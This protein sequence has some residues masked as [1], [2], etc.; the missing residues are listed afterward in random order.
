MAAAEACSTVPPDRVYFIDKD[1][2]R[3]VAFA[4]SKEIPDPR[5]THAHEHLHEI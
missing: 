5:G 3:C 2:A 4:L 1:D